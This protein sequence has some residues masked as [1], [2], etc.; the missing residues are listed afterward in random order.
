MTTQ[1]LTDAQRTELLDFIA[2]DQERV[3]AENARMYAALDE[4]QRDRRYSPR[5]DDDAAQMEALRLWHTLH[6]QA[7]AWHRRNKALALGL[8]FG[9]VTLLVIVWAVWL[10]AAA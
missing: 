2:A 10:W 4:V 5:V 8:L 9:V 7:A 3:A 1:S 6:P